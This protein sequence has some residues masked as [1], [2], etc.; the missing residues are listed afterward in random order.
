M[1]NYHCIASE[2]AR[3]SLMTQQNELLT[4]TTTKMQQHAAAMTK[5]NE[6][7]HEPN[8]KDKCS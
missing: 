8:A 5:K 4:T 3:I 2:Y 1:H 7:K 6:I